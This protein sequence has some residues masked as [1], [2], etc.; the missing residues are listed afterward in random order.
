MLSLII[1]YAIPQV[2]ETSLTIDVP[3][4]D[5]P[6]GTKVITT[7]ESINANNGEHLGF[8]MGLNLE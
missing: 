3:D 5:G 7:T 8:S 2:A 1:D 4:I 6:F